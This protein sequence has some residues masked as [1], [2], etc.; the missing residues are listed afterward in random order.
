MRLEVVNRR[1]SETSIN[2]LYYND[3][4]DFRMHF[5]DMTIAKFIII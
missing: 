5:S 3:I 2:C 1:H 4:M